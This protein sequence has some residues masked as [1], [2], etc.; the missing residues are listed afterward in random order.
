GLGRA[1]GPRNDH[2]HLE[3]HQLGDQRGPPP[4]LALVPAVF[5]CDR[6][7]L[8]VV[9]VAQP[10]PEGLHRRARRGTRR[11]NADARDLFACWAATT[12]GAMSIPQAS[13]TSSPRALSRMGLSSRWPLH[14]VH[15]EHVGN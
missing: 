13:M 3:C 9:E 7:A 10:L 15:P 8:D 2:I 5:E 11:E 12:S 4:G 6:L 14:A 1:I